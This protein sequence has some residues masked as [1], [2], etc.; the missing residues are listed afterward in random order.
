MGT[1]V[2]PDVFQR[3]L[4]EIFHN[5]QGVTGIA[6]EMVIYGESIEDHDKHF[7]NLL[8]LVTKNNL[9][10]N[11]SKLQFQL[12]EVSFFGHNWSSKVISPDPRKIQAIQQIVFPRD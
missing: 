8:S 5:V 6:D 10:L 11:A 9:R 2:A 4:D 1:I 7:L 3:K 12:E